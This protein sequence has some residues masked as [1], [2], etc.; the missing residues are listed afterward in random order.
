M[1]KRKMLLSFVGFSL[2]FIMAICVTFAWFI[3]ETN[4]NFPELNVEPPIIESYEVHF[5]THDRIYKYDSTTHKLKMYDEATSGWI[6]P[7]YNDTEEEGKLFN[8]IFMGQY[9]PLIPEN[10][11]YS[12]III[13]FRL[14]HNLK[15]N[16]SALFSI[17]SNPALASDAIIVFEPDPVYYLSRFVYVQNMITTKFERNDGENIF[18]TVTDAFVETTYPLKSFYD[19]NNTYSPEISLDNIDFVATENE[20]GDDIYLYINLSYYKDKIESEFRNSWGTGLTAKN[21]IRFFQDITFFIR[22]IEE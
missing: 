17:I 4:V 14:H 16:T 11:K 3:L 20:T 1:E 8:G 13:E 5:F 6:D 21:S 7:N 15:T 12:N 19:S 18:Q 2:T 9:D 22:K 10:N